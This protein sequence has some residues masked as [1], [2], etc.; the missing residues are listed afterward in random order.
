MRFRFVLLTAALG[1]AGLLVKPAYVGAQQCSSATGNYTYTTCLIDLFGN[2]KETSHTIYPACATHPGQGSLCTYCA[3]RS[4]RCVS[5][6]C[7]ANSG[8]DS[9]CTADETLSVAG[10]GCSPVNGTWGSWSS[11]YIGGGGLCLHDRTCNGA[12][13]GGSCSGSSWEECAA[14]SCCTPS[15]GDTGTV[16]AGTTYNDSCGNPTCTGTKGQDCSGSGTVCSGTPYADPNGCGS[17]TGTKDCTSSPTCTVQGFK[18]LMPGNQRNNPPTTTLTDSQPVYKDGVSPLTTNPYFHSQ[19]STSTYSVPALSGYT[20]GYTL[21]YNRND[22]HVVP[23]ATITQ[24]NSVPVDQATCLLNSGPPY[25]YADLWWHYTRQTGTIQARAV[26][27]DPILTSCATIRAGGTGGIPNTS[28]QF[29]PS[30]VSHP[31]NQTQS[32][33]SYVVFNNAVIGDYIILPSVPAGYV[34]VRYCSSVPPPDD[35]TK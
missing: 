1:I 5:G 30:S 12:S 14:G 20:I 25:P 22:C 3:P 26:T 19:T 27:V 24:A 34:L 7:V 21:C 23:P 6:A 33:S 10:C 31:A 13:C 9:G 35:Q 17:C 2:C 11:C 15:C 32:G 29:T 16:C 28:I 4:I 8:G 18:V